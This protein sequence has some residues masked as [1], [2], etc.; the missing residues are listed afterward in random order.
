MTGWDTYY[1]PSE[2]YLSG[3][4]FTEEPTILDEEVGNELDELSKRLVFVRDELK[5]NRGRGTDNAAP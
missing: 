3:K 5:K 4:E 1:K 2:L